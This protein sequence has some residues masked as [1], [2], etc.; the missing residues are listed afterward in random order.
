MVSKWLVLK[1][2]YVIIKLFLGT[3][4][5]DLPVMETERCSCPS[6]KIIKET[7]TLSCVLRGG[8]KKKKPPLPFIPLA[9][10]FSPLL[11]RETSFDT[12]ALCTVELFPYLL[13]RSCIYI[14]FSVSLVIRM[15]LF[16]TV[17]EALFRD[18][19]CLCQLTF[20]LTLLCSQ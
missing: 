10:T 13:P 20:F 19:V 18:C 17:S 5:L 16:L 14:W 12:I 15:F 11:S 9:L 4:C 2:S 6:F 1:W 8:I 7:Q 3:T